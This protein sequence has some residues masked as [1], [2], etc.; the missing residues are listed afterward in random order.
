VALVERD[1]LG[2]VCVNSGCTPTKTM[3]AC[4]RLFAMLDG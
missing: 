1:H 4:A 2:G 3:V